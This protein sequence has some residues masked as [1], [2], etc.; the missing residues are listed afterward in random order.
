VERRSL[1]FDH[2]SV[3]AI[4]PNRATA[5]EDLEARPNARPAVPNR[6]GTETDDHLPV[7]SQAVKRACDAC[8]RR[9]VKCDGINPCRNCSSAQLSCTYNAI[10]Q[11]KGPKGSR[12]KVISELRE[13]QRQ[14]SLSHKVQ[15]RMNG[16]NC[17]PAGSSAA[18]TPG[19]LTSEMVKE[20]VQFFFDNMYA[21]LPI[22]DRRQLEQQIL[23]MEQNRD[24]YCLMTSL[25]AFIMLQ[26]GMAMPPGDPYNLDMVPGANIISS[27]LLLEETLRVRRG[28]EY[29]DSISPNA[30]ATNFFLYGCYYGQESHDRAWYY[31][32]EATTMVHMVGMHKEEYY[33]QLDPAEASR[34]RRLFWLLFV[35]ERAYAIQRGRP[36]T[37]Q[38]TIKLPTAADDPADPLA[39]Q[40]SSFILLVNLFRP[41]DEALTSTWNKT[42]G[43]LSAQYV[44][45]LQKQLNELAQSYLC[46]DSN[47]NDLRT[48]QQWLKN[49]VWQLTNGVVNN[50]EDSMSYQYPVDMARQLLMS[51][52]SQFPGQGMELMN[53]GLMDK[54]I[55]SADTMAEFLSM[56]P[57]SRDPF[58]T[59]PREHLNQMLNIVAMSRNGDHRFLPLLMSKVTEVL[60]R[61]INPMLQNAPE[62]SN[63]A[64]VDIFDGFGNAGMAQPPQQQQSQQM[65]MQMD[66]DYDQYESKY[67]IEMGGTPESASN[68]NNSHGTPQVAQQANSE[69]NGSFVGSPP[70]MSPAIEYQHGMNN[71][72]CTP[73]N[74]MVMSPLG[75]QQNPMNAAHGQQHQHMAAQQMNHGHEGI[76]QQQ[77]HMNG[78]AQQGMRSQVNTA[79]MGNMNSFPALRQPP[80]RQNSF[81]MQSPQQ[82]RTPIVG[83]NS[84]N[85]E[86]DFGALR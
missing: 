67:N 49:T 78:V 22:L 43:H 71:F 19:L 55:G 63:L 56:Q 52:A 72:A 83:M 3:E 6:T 13:N 15:N 5:L 37:L 40:L 45:G 9:K 81:H 23:Y 2:R 36:L 74:E 66:N 20:C 61:L 31:L 32:R 8:H 85:A 34:Q 73:M 44:T 47:F 18:P 84:M 80:Q 82:I 50:G 17:S 53:S 4:T 75:N 38:A 69:M 16:I 48:N 24:A 26:P 42:R 14:T 30:L 1:A 46:Q 35:T 70:I 77:H 11:K 12:A 57:A 54:L 41:F 79:A 58:A 59:G 29:L 27:Q 25:C 65:S 33:M 39:H 10:P 64:N 21:Q 60:P 28:Y 51:M 76:G 68:S 86:I 62:N 7:M